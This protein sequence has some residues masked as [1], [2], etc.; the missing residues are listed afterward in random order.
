MAYKIKTTATNGKAPIK[1]TH[2]SRSNTSPFK[3][4]EGMEPPRAERAKRDNTRAERWP[5]LERGKGGMI[6]DTGK[7]TE[8]DRMS[9]ERPLG[10]R[11]ERPGDEKVLDPATRR[12]KLKEEERASKLTSEGKMLKSPMTGGLSTE[13]REKTTKTPKDPWQTKVDD[14]RKSGIGYQTT[15]KRDDDGNIIESGITFDDGEYLK[16]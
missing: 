1:T 14:K 12:E 2:S 13:K 6:E 5:T 15:Y 8:Y 16:D 9:P 10:T 4:T 11:R 3:Q 7:K